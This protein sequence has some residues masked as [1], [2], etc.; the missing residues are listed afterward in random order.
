MSKKPAKKSRPASKSSKKPAKPAKK[1]AKPVAKPAAKSAA[2]PRPAGNPLRDRALA[3]FKFAHKTTD[4]FASGFSDAQM[5]AMPCPTSNH[6]LWNL[7]HLAV[8]NAW[9]ASMIDGAPVGVEE[10]WDKMF[11]MNSKP[12]ADASAYPSIADVRAMYQKTA[13]RLEDAARARTDADLA[14]PPTGDSGGFL[15]DRL[16]AVLKAAWH[17]GWHLGQIAE[18]RKALGLPSAMSS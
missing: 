5:T 13:E 2:A 18:C 17:E 9:F 8:S 10:S 3:I 12:V 16:D 11:G 6:V 7:G 1:A 14:Q 15:A 4:K